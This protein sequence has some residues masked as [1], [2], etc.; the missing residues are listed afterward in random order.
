M[1]KLLFLALYSV[2]LHISGY[3]S[4]SD[5][6][7]N[8]D[9]QQI[10]NVQNSQNE[11][12]VSPVV[13]LKAIP[14]ALT[15]VKL[16][17]GP[18]KHAQEVD[19]KFLLSLKVD[20]L[21]SRYLS[22]AGLREKDVVYDCGWERGDGGGQ[23]LGHY[24]SACSMMYASTG[25]MK[26]KEKVDYA[27]NEL[28][29]CQLER[30]GYLGFML[31]ENSLWDHLAKGDIRAS[32]GVLNGYAVPIYFW[33]KLWAGLVDA[34]I[35]TGNEKAKEILIGVAHWF[36]EKM[37][38]LSDAQW[39]QIL[40]A[41][42]GGML[43][44]IAN[45]YALTGDKRFL[46]M[47]NWFYHK[48]FFRPLLAKQDSLAWIHANTQIP[49]VVGIER[50]YQLTG[51]INDHSIADFFWQ[52][53]VNDHTYCNGGNSDREHFGLPGQLSDR[54]SAETTETCNTYNMLKLTKE[55]IIANPTVTAADYY[56]KALY[57][58]I[59]A[60]ENPSTGGFTYF[61][62]LT[63]GCE[64]IYQLDLFTCCMGTGMENHAKYGEAIYFK[65]EDNGLF[66]NLFIP[67][68][69]NW[70]EKN[71]KLIQKHNY[72]LNGDIRLEVATT[73]NQS[74]P[75]Y[76]RYPSWANKGAELIINGKK[77]RLTSKPGSYI[78]L[79]RTW[80]NKD[81]IEL[82]LSM[83]LYLEPMPDK[84]DRA[85]I[86]YGPLVLVGC[87]GKGEIRSYDIPILKTSGK[88][89]HQWLKQINKDSCI[90]STLNVGFPHDIILKPFF[91]V[92][93]QKYA[94]YFDFFSEK[95]L[96][97]KEKSYREDLAAEELLNQNTVDL[98]HLGEM[99]PERDHNFK[100]KGSLSGIYLGRKYRASWHNGYFSFDMKVDPSSQM[101]LV[102]TFNWNNQSPP[103]AYNRG[104]IQYGF[105]LIVGNKIIASIDHIPE[106]GT[107]DTF[108]DKKFN[109]PP[110]LINGKS[111][112][113]VTVKAKKDSMVP[114]FFDCRIIR[115]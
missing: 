114:R 54:L 43:E 56:E 35:Y 67:S 86:K 109:L 4:Q 52:T 21:L 108:Y 87:L 51:N 23:T 37:K 5:Y 45:V 22:H 6:V 18:F 84:A 31:G 60:S 44:S 113:S 83:P 46:D 94:V 1:K 8:Q 66:V 71:I 26:L 70:K 15:D 92:Y 3:S 64:R 82:K 19:E 47:T 79:Q 61:V 49:K 13:K 14:F 102:C 25:N 33:H 39:Q 16:L 106:K 80:S 74:F 42:H 72:P 34:Y 98:F 103:Q 81:C 2:V 101:Q 40:V 91:Q 96:G 53:V 38:G 95:T 10:N 50:R 97:E 85:A 88:P 110:E 75:I 78:K 12:A 69:L 112:I 24:L 105:D 17:P 76:L 36:Y 27:I 9:P 7:T 55:L 29:R 111:T 90:F 32:G 48:K 100:D 58:H 68:E 77:E 93:D 59:L 63:S 65:S 41:E 99:Q 73:N 115:K 107:D 57:N 28:A 89:I 30:D 62:P 11:F 20:K 104:L